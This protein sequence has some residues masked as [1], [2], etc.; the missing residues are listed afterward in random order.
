MS[1]ILGVGG[2]NVAIFNKFS[3]MMLNVL[4]C[5]FMSSQHSCGSNI[6]LKSTIYHS[7]Q[8]QPGFLVE[9]GIPGFLLRPKNSWFQPG[10]QDS[11]FSWFN[12]DS[13]TSTR[14]P[15]SNQDFEKNQD[16]YFSWFNPRCFF[17]PTNFTPTNC[18]SG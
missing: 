8:E 12:Q 7:N 16:S 18:E 14:I 15:G 1:K 6:R 4:A 2:R 11:C 13:T 10:Y 17:F 5:M 9:P 3:K